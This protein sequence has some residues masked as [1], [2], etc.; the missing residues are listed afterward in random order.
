MQNTLFN[1]G[2]AIYGVAHLLA[3]LLAALA[4]VGGWIFLIV[5]GAIF[6]VAIW[7]I[8]GTIVVYLAVSVLRLPFVLI[9]WG[10]A[11]LGGRTQDYW[12]FVQQTNDR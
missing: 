11:A 10:F 8:F 1:T 4:Y 3:G 5:N 7:A 12:S 2:L 6:W 9:G